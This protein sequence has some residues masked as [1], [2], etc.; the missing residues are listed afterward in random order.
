MVR[1]SLDGRMPDGSLAPSSDAPT[2]L[3]LYRLFPD[4]GG[5]AHT[6]STMAT[7]RAQAGC[8]SPILGTTHADW[9]FGA[10]PCTWPLL[11]AG[12]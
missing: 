8:A 12:D 5:V 6:H 7:A 4:I 9:F 10:V 2:H 1:L 11:A 3:E